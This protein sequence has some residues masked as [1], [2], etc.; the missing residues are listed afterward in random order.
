M[1]MPS[2]HHLENIQNLE[3]LDHL[4]P[5]RARWTS[6]DFCV[7]SW[8]TPLL[9]KEAKTLEHNTPAI[10]TDSASLDSCPMRLFFTSS[11][12][13]LDILWMISVY[14]EQTSES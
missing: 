11:Y 14:C 5:G 2:P 1:Q 7:A 12:S 8:E 6:S 3:N 10:H 4:L 9:E 13:Y